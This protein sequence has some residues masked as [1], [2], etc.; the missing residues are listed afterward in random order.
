MS[1]QSVS[2]GKALNENLV[3]GRGILGGTFDPIH[4]GHLRIALEVW[5]GLGL[6]AVHLIPNGVPPHRD[7]PHADSAQRL[8]MVKLAID[9]EPSLVA[10]TLEI[11]RV[12]SSLGNSTASQSYMV[13]TLQTVRAGV[14]VDYPLFLIMG[15]DAF[16]QLDTWHRWD[17][18]IQYSHLVLVQ[19]PGWSMPDEHPMLAYYKAHENRNDQDR[20]KPAG[21]IFS[22][23][24]SQLEVSAST[25]RQRVKN[26]QSIRYLVPTAVDEYIQQHGLYL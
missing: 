21:R 19:R 7:M 25:L 14:G 13:D 10:D 18:L 16:L 1:N 26:G 6:D 22:I 8:A 17:E 5:E 15:C 4:I 9:D 3:G 11:D 23:V 20:M 12:V 24:C 2:K